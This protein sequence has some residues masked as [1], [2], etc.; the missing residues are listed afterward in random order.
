METP[1]SIRSAPACRG[2]FLPGT[3]PR[4]MLVNWHIHLHHHFLISISQYQTRTYKKLSFFDQALRSV[5]QTIVRSIPRSSRALALEDRA[6]TDL[7]QWSRVIPRTKDSC[8]SSA[9]SSGCS[10]WPS[11]PSGSGQRASGGDR[12]A[13]PTRELDPSGASPLTIGLRSA[14][15]TSAS[16]SEGGS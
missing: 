2:R 8:S 10:T 16:D 1:C 12:R 3:E 6:S 9:G 7:I 15:T 13:A 5:L 4:T 14:T 11:S